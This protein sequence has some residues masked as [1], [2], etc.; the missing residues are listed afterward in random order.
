MKFDRRSFGVKLWLYFTLFAA[1]ILVVLWLLQTVFLQSFYEDM[2]TRDIL[3]VADTLAAAYGQDDF[4]TVVDRTAYTNSILVYVTDFSGT[5]LY[6]T[7][8]HGPARQKDNTPFKQNGPGGFSHVLPYGYDGFLTT[9]AESEGGR[10]TY[11]VDRGDIT[12]GGFKSKSL[13]CGARL[14]DD[15]ALY[16]TTPLDPV[17]ATTG[18][19]RTQL[20]YVTVIALVLSLVIAF[21]IARKFSSPVAA[22][23]R[24]AED[25]ARGA[26]PDAFDKGFCAELDGLAET[27]TYASG[28]LKKVESLRRELIANI[29]HDLRTPLTMIKAYA[30]MIRDISGEDRA[31]R[32]QHL[33]VIAGEAD[34]LTA[35][36]SDLLA[37]S[38]IQSG[39]ET[40]HPENLSISDTVVKVAGQFG[41]YFAQEG[42]TLETAIEPDQYAHADGPKIEQVLYNLIANA[43]HNIG[44]DKRAT[45]RVDDLGG[46]VRV[47]VSDRGQG[48]PESE[49]PLIWDRY[50]K[51]KTREG[52]KA[53]TGLGLSIVKGIL[54][55]HGARFGVR[56]QEG[57][58][59]DFWFELK[60]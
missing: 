26:Y 40:I 51:S 5:I 38:S 39:N 4:E 20:V 18:I 23:T 27:L 33:A 46:A 24:Q 25:L 19:L 17:E 37:L 42:C 30:E 7:D 9:L 58:G 11:T 52:G 45:V 49:L 10:L 43:L 32:E 41:P 13:I 21:F 22:I 44:P 54:T 12:R 3:R 15:A 8:E 60:K 56:S 47:T 2:K 6:A 57:A 48:I 14:G 35:L 53:G 29:S 31:K 50:Y 34:R 1:V 36:V 28:E 55:L 16:I 59:S